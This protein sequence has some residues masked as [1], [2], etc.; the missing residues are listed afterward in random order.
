M[1]WS[2]KRRKIT[3]EAILRTFSLAIY[4]K[5]LPPITAITV[6]AVIPIEAPRNTHQA[7]PYEANVIV[8][9]CALSPQCAK[10]TRV[11]AYQNTAYV[12]LSIGTLFKILSTGLIFKYVAVGSFGVYFFSINPACK[13]FNSVSVIP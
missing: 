13:L 4:D 12:K 7:S 10:N 3:P 9:I 2:P 11:A 1:L 8:A 6:V 5:I